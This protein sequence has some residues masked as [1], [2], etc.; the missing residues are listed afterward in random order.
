MTTRAPETRPDF[1]D[2]AATEQAYDILNARLAKLESRS[3]RSPIRRVLGK[4]ALLAAGA[5]L[6]LGVASGSDRDAA[7][8]SV[9]TDT[10]TEATATMPTD[11]SDMTVTTPTD[12]AG[13]TVTTPTDT[14]TTETTPTD[15]TARPF[16]IE[17]TLNSFHNLNDQQRGQSYFDYIREN[18]DTDPGVQEFF[19]RLGSYWIGGVPQGATSPRPTSPGTTP[20]APGTG[21][22]RAT[23]DSTRTDADDATLMPQ[24]KYGNVDTGSDAQGLIGEFNIDPSNPSKSRA[25]FFNDIR[26][27]PQALAFW[28][29][30]LDTGVPNYDSCVASPAALDRAEALTRQYEGLNP[31]KKGQIAEGVIAK[32][33]KM[34]FGVITHSGPYRTIATTEDGQFIAT[35]LSRQGDEWLQFTTTTDSGKRVTFS[36]RECDQ[37]VE[38]IKPAPAPVRAPIVA[39]ATPQASGAVPASTTQ[40]PVS[41]PISPRDAPAPI[42]PRDAPEIP[43]TR[44]A[45]VPRDEP[46]VPP[47]VRPRTPET[48]PAVVVVPPVE[49]PPVVVPPPVTPPSDGKN[50]EDS[51]VTSDPNHPVEILRPNIEAPTVA[52]QPITAPAVDPYPATAPVVGNPGRPDVVPDPRPTGEQE[53]TPTPVSTPDTN[54]DPAVDNGNNNPATGI[55]TSP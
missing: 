35:T 2:P 45:D 39:K 46:R 22:D 25:N 43:F 49:T 13:S 9:A 42:P 26:R 19:G 4:V 50:A 30:C 16:S 14:T 33:K 44:P 15:P 24:S 7:A 11:T 8:E 48:P 51:P 32:F 34:Q 29:T 53:G 36:V 23:A 18:P 28:K 41:R 31:A 54:L 38:A 52:V 17:A 10:T 55:V 37:L 47:Q 3:S 1:T 21:G 6:A 5:V 27:N 20:E 12:T 40:P